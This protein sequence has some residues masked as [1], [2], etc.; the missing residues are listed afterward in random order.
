MAITNN[1]HESIES[2]RAA[3]FLFDGTGKVVGE[4]SKWIIGGSKDQ[5]KLAPKTGTT[6]NFVITSSQ[7]FT[8]TNFTAQ[9]SVS[10]L[11][12]QGQKLAN[13]KTEVEIKSVNAK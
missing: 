10:Q 6:F 13:P 5:P 7:Q 11:V 9:L 4:S 12:L 8:T 2:A 1:L 3:C